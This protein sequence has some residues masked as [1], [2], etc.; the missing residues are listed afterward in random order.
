MRYGVADYG[1]GVWDGGTFDTETRWEGLLSI[2][3]RL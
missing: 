2:L 3:H 1:M